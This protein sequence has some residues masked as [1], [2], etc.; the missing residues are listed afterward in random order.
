VNAHDHAAGRRRGHPGPGAPRRRA[1]AP[2]D[3]GGRGGGDAGRL[4]AVRAARR[5]RRIPGRA[6]P[7]RR[8]VRPGA[9]GHGG[10]PRRPAARAFPAHHRGDR[11]HD[12]GRH[13]PGLP[14]GRAARRVPGALRPVL[15]RRGADRAGPGGRGG[16]PAGQPGPAAPPRPPRRHPAGIRDR[17][18]A[19]RAGRGPRLG[20]GVGHHPGL[21]GRVR[22]AARGLGRVGAAGPSPA[23]RPAPAPA[24]AGARRQRHRVRGGRRVLPAG[25]AGGPLRADPARGGLR[26]RR[27]GGSRRADA[28]PV[29]RGQLRR[30]QD[31]HPGRPAHLPRARGRGELRGADR[32][33]GAVPR[34]AGQL[35]RHRGDHGAGRLRRGLRVRGQPAADHQRRARRPDRQRDQLLPAR[36]HRRVLHRQRAERD[37][38]RPVHPRRAARPGRR[39]LQRRRDD[40]HRGPGRRARGQRPVRGG[41]PTARRRPGAR[42]DECTFRRPVAR[43]SVHARAGLSGRRASRRQGPP[44]AGSRAPARAPAGGSTARDRPV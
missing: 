4:R 24:P 6:G 30:Q 43:P 36:A 16:G 27:L 1:A 44:G 28:H 2:A 13:R 12:R 21:R 34:R 42:R 35:R 15:V 20:L 29:L 3:H 7:A 32:L 33:D 25:V 9:A 18:V 22:G 23:G 19:A 39:R 8:R 5:V 11:D 17:G 37:G 10:R 31:R 14:A 38:A 41:G 26:L 40:Q